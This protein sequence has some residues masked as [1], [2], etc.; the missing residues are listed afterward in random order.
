MKRADV[1]QYR[2][3]GMDCARDAADIEDAARAAPHVAAVKVSTASH[4]LTVQTG[5]PAASLTELEQAVTRLGYRLE[6]L[7]VHAADGA[8]APRPGQTHQTSS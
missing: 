7:L 3:M 8:A 6:P 5:R 4:I 1:T 2:V